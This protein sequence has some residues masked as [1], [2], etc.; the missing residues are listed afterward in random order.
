LLSLTMLSG[1]PTVE[2]ATDPGEFF[3]N[4]RES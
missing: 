3:V 1:N 2:N 4:A